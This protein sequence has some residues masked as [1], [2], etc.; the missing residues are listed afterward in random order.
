MN[1]THLRLHERQLIEEHVKKGMACEAIGKLIGRSKNCIVS[2]VRRNG[3]RDDYNAKEAHENAYTKQLGHRAH[4]KKL[5]DEQG[6]PWKR[7]IDKIEILQMQ[8]DILTETIKQ[9]KG[10]YDQEN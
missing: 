9:M 8:V 1:S 2:E 5:L 10:N 7:M 6:N 4:L 3:G